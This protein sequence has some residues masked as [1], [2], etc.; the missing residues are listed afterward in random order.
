MRQKLGAKEEWKKQ[1]NE[2]KY[3]KIPI[4]AIKTVGMC[5]IHVMGAVISFFL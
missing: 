3:N 4:K 2:K 5:E 1:N